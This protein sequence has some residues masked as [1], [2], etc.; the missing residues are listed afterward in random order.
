VLPK[1]DASLRSELALSEVLNEVKE[2]TAA[3]LRTASVVTEERRYGQTT[4]DKEEPE[5]FNQKKH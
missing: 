3:C 1:R 4:L 5:K 2:Q